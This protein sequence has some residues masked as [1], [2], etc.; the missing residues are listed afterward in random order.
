MVHENIF[1]RRAA[2]ESVTFFSVEPLHGSFFSHDVL[3]FLFKQKRAA[4]SQELQPFR[5]IRHKNLI[6][7]AEQYSIAGISARS[8]SR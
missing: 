5:P 3:T 2:D 8:I 7:P 6:R 4:L 1:S